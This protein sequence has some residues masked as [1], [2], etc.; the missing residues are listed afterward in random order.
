MALTELV[1]KGCRDDIVR[2]F[3]GHVVERIIDFEIEQRCSAAYGA[4]TT[5]RANSRNGYCERFW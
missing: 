3:L 5:D 2:E 4:R 1:E